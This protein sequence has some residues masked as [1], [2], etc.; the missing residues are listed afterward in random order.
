M[1]VFESTSH[2]NDDDEDYMYCPRCSLKRRPD[3]KLC[4]PCQEEIALQAS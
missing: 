3:E 1:N 4:E 2:Y